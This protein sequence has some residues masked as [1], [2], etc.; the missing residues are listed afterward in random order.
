MAGSL[1]SETAELSRHASACMLLLL[2]LSVT[3]LT[4]AGFARAQNLQ[5][6]SDQNNIQGTVVNAVT[7]TPI[8]RALVHSADDRYAV[9]SDSDGHFEFTTP[10][11]VQLWLLARKPGFLGDRNTGRAVQTTSGSDITIP[12]TP[13]SIIKGRVTASTGDAP[14]RIRVE[15]LSRQIRDGLARWTPVNN[16]QTRSDGSFRFAELPAGP[17]KVMTQESLDNDP[18]LGPNAQ[19]YGFPPVYFPSAPDFSGGATIDLAA[20]QTVE[21]N[22]TITAQPYYPVKIPVANGEMN[23]GMDVRVTLQGRSG[24]GYS[25]GYNVA[26]H[27]IEGALP[28]GSY[29]VRAII[30]GQDSKSGEVNLRVSGAPAEGP[31]LMLIHNS[32]LTLDVQAAF[33]EDNQASALYGRHGRSSDPRAYLNPQLDPA[34]DF[35]QWGGGVRRPQIDQNDNSLVIDNVLPGRYWLRLATGRGYVS[36]ATMGGLDLLHQPFEV[37]SGSN[38]P[39]EVTLRDD[40]ATL[41]GTVGNSSSSSAGTQPAWVYC[42]PLADSPGQIQEVSVGSSDGKFSLPQIAPGSY[43]VMA[44]DSP[45]QIPYR[46]PGAMRAYDSMGQVVQLAA[47][48]N[49]SVQLQVIPDD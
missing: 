23:A 48:Q 11:G 44:F 42:V 4:L 39:I 2:S 36:S 45:K 15:L 49:V 6:S 22:L 29:T 10:S 19:S 46:D 16:T 31:P 33:T 24:P 43:R 28:N 47:G 18:V 34:D 9:M 41:Q 25:L 17:Y 8:A 35:A 32:S 7:H 13:E 12:L 14:T 26:S 30:Y 27:K 38:I 40:T 37:S 1:R 3:G 5:S 20:G 21:A